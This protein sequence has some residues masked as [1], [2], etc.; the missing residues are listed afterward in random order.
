MGGRTILGRAARPERY[1]A[2]LRLCSYAVVSLGFERLAWVE[3]P[4]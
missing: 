2:C 3:V 4:G 1:G